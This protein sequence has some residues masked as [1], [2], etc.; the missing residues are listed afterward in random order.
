M[1]AFL[2]LLL[3][4]ASILVVDKSSSYGKTSY[5]D[6]LAPCADH[7]DLMKAMKRTSGITIARKEFKNSVGT[8]IGVQGGVCFMAG[9]TWC[10]VYPFREAN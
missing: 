2:S 9:G 7:G 4:A 1:A 6:I 5:K 3:E 8:S 10:G